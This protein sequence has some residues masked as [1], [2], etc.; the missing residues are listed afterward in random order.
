V[1]LGGERVLL[2]QYDIITD[3][4]ENP[5]AIV[6]HGKLIPIQIKTAQTEKESRF[7]EE[8]VVAPLNGQVAKI[9]AEIGRKVEQGDVVLVLEA[10][11]MENEIVAP[12]PGI[13]KEVWVQETEVVKKGTRLF[14]IEPA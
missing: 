13:L 7:N 12:A 9:K 1:S 14:R 5:T 6:L 3:D 2:L 10:M 4:T 8:E 11:K